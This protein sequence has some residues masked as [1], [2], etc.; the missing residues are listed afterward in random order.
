MCY[1]K[2][3]TLLLHLICASIS[4]VSYF[5]QYYEM[6]EYQVSLFSIAAVLTIP[7]LVLWQMQSWLIIYLDRVPYEK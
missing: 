2:W 6:L 1:L 4:G 5:F 7:L 3:C